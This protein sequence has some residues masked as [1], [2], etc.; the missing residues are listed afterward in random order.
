MSAQ[1]SGLKETN[2]TNIRDQGKTTVKS[3]DHNNNNIKPAMENGDRSK[4]E[5]NATTAAM[6]EG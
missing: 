6:T 5:E 2:R 1:A 3:D 4:K